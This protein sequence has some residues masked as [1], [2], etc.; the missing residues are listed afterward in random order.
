MKWSVWVS[1][2]SALLFVRRKLLVKVRILN[3]WEGEG[4]SGAAEA[5]IPNKGP[6]REGGVYICSWYLFIII[7]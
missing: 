5:D 4:M 1:V 7:I 3:Y 6:Q 2:C